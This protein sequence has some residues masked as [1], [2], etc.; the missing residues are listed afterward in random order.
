MNQS[1]QD[2]YEEV[3]SPFSSISSGTKS[4]TKSPYR[5]RLRTRK[6][7][8]NRP[9]ATDSSHA[10]TYIEPKV[11]RRSVGH[12][13][14]TEFIDHRK[15]KLNEAQIDYLEDEGGYD[16][17]EEVEVIVEKRSSKNTSGSVGS[18]LKKKDK[19]KKNLLL[20]L[21]WTTIGVL[22]LRLIFMDRGVWDYFSTEGV[23]QDK[24]AELKS[25]VVENKELRNEILKV[26]LDRNYQ[27]QLAKEH[28]GVIAADEF[29]I[30]FAGESSEEPLPEN[31]I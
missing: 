17:E 10:P 15:S 21:G 5:E 29:L 7:V 30:L 19:N 1:S 22:I 9:F 20:K 4:G 2:E 24:K 16:E 28:L 6:N 8:F 3:E 18:S 13:D 26:Q 31:S 12:A 27:K 23:I 14:H 11:T 25:I